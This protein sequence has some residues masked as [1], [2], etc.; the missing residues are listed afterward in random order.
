MKYYYMDLSGMFTKVK[1]TTEKLEYLP[2][3]VKEITEAEYNEFIRSDREE[4]P[5]I[6]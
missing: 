4:I 3:Y 5:N 2:K 1:V 6:Y